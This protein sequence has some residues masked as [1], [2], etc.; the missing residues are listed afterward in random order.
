[1]LDHGEA[2]V[3]EIVALLARGTDRDYGHELE[4]RGKLVESYPRLRT[5]LFDALRL[6]DTEETRRELLVAIPRA[7]SLADYRDLLRLFADTDDQAIAAAI[8]R[9]VPKALRTLSQVGIANAEQYVGPLVPSLTQWI[10]KHR[11]GNTVTLIEQL[12]QQ[13]PPASDAYQRMLGLLIELE[14]ERAAQVAGIVRSGNP[15]DRSYSRFALRFDGREVPLAQIVKF[16]DRVLRD[17]DLDLVARRDLY[18]S[19][20]SGKGS[21]DDVQKLIELLAR[22]AAIESDPATQRLLEAKIEALNAGR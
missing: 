17:V 18:R 12:A 9:M 19:M 6:I 1:V 3:P 21:G 7:A 22:R 15:D 16:Y 8:T 11:L 2:I 4:T 10:R 5:A 13:S 14:P 20:P